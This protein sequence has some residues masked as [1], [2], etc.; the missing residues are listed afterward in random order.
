MLWKYMLHENVGI[1]N[2]V[3]RSIGISAPSWFSTK[4]YALISSILID[5]WEWTPFMFLV[6]L[7]GLQSLPREPFEASLIDGA[8]KT[9]IFVYITLPL[10]RPIIFIAVLL[11]LMRAVTVFDILYVTTKGGPGI[12]TESITYYIFNM[13]IKQGDVGTGCAASIITL[14]IVF[15][16]FSL[17]LRYR[18]K[19]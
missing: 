6:L 4:P 18:P 19:V 11:M 14:F 8:S 1:V 9:Q 13:A 3:L 5:V 2:Y 16:I 10:M 12:Y 17:Y 15:G 7:A